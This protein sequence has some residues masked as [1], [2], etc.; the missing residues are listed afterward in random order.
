M[1]SIFWFVILFLN[2]ILLFM[3]LQLSQLFPFGPLPSSASPLPQAV[4]TLLLMSMGNAYMFFGYSIPYAIL[5][6]VI[7]LSFF[8]N[9]FFGD[10]EFFLKDF[11]DLFSEKGEGREKEREISMCGCLSCGPH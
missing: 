10:S 7:F 2:Y 9:K 5:S 6:D 11:I 3:L 8:F 4:P 1:Y